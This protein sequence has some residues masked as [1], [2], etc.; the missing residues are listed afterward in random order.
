MTS[1]SSLADADVPTLAKAAE[2]FLASQPW[3]AR[4]QQATQVF[5]IVGIVGVFPDSVDSDVE[6]TLK[7]SK[8]TIELFAA[9]PQTLI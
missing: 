2:Q 1:E 4:V 9:P 3:C 8:E 6:R 5:A 7:L